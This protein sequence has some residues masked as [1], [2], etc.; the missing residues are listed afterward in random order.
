[1]IR[2]AAITRK[3]AVKADRVV[4]TV[5]LDHEARHRRRL[6]LTGEKGLEFLLDLEKATVLNDGDAAKLEDGRLVLIKAAPQAL[7]AI[8]ANSPE[9]LLKLAWHIGNRHTPRRDYG[10]GDLYRRGPCARRNGARP[11]RRGDQRDAAV[12]RRKRAPITSMAAATTITATTTMTM[13]TVIMIM[14]T[15][16]CTGRAADTTITTMAITTMRI[17]RMIT[18]TSMT[19]ITS[20]I[21]CTVRVVA[22]AMITAMTMA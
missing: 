4:D 16:M 9:R 2:A 17:T 5:V 19:M 3:P 21:T 11:W 22:A 8:S 18:L 15:G 13:I 7:L 10:R 6:V 12:S 1:M 14:T 20:T